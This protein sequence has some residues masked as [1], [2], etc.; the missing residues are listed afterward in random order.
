MLR[1]CVMLGLL[2]QRAH[3]FISTRFIG[4]GLSTAAPSA[5]EKVVRTRPRRRAPGWTALSASSELVNL[6][7]LDQEG[8]AEFIGQRKLGP[9]YRAAQLHKC[10]LP[11]L[12]ASPTFGKRARARHRLLRPRDLDDRPR[13]I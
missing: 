8:L 11:V 2:P 12:P 6:Y 7:G 1:V 3:P 5:P 10:V 4:A 9:K 13:S